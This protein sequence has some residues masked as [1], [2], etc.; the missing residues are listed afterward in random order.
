MVMLHFHN[1]NMVFLQ[2]LSRMELY[3]RGINHQKKI[4]LLFEY[5][6]ILRS[7]FGK[8]KCQV[9]RRILVHQG[10]LYIKINFY[11]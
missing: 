9:I 2:W 6:T 10:Q 8:K 4:A 1:L 5:Y 7:C 11:W 3:C